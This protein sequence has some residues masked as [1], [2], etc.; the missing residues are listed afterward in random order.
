MTAVATAC[1]R[2][3]EEAGVRLVEA[4]YRVE[5]AT[6]TRGLDAATTTVKS[7]R[8]RILE[9]AAREGQDLF[10]ICAQIPVEACLS[11]RGGGGDGSGG[12]SF[13]DELRRLTSGA[14]SASLSISHWERLQVRAVC[15]ACVL[16]SCAHQD[17]RARHPAH[18]DLCLPL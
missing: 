16:R 3:V 15:W 12:L 7:R 13:A 1:R 4:H 17:S 5:V 18:P 11:K 2:A 6:S 8:G 10:V 9:T 14:A